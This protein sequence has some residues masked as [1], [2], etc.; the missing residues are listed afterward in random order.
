MIPKG[1]LLEEDR[2]R[3]LIRTCTFPNQYLQKKYYNFRSIYH[4]SRIEKVYLSL[5]KIGVTL[6]IQA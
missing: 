1:S 5:E 4:Y 2:R 3:L 6:S